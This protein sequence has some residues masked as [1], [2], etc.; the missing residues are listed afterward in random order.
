MGCQP[1]FYPDSEKIL[2]QTLDVRTRVKCASSSLAARDGVFSSQ[3]LW[4]KYGE[5]IVQ[6]GRSKQGSAIDKSDPA[7]GCVKR[8]YFRCYNKACP[9]RMT[10][11]VLLCSGVQLAPDGSGMHT[12]AFQICPIEDNAK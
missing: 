3:K 10:V 7:S 2:K 5:K 8:S 12:H 4:K 1:A 9:A 11:D 6:P